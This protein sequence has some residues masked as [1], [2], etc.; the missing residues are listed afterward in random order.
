MY[1]GDLT[2]IVCEACSSHLRF[3]QCSRKRIQKGMSA[4]I[5]RALV[6]I[7]DSV[8]LWAGAGRN[9]AMF[10]FGMAVVAED[11]DAFPTGRRYLGG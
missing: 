4:K 1:L 9:R 8:W 2:L 11:V 10:S 7:L 5:A 6:R 3:A